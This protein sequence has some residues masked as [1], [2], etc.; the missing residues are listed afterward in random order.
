[1]THRPVPPTVGGRSKRRPILLL[2]VLATVGITAAAPLRLQERNEL[3]VLMSSGF[4]AAY[5]ELVPLFE[6]GRG[7][8]LTTT[9]GGSVGP[10]QNTIAARLARGEVAD[11]VILAADGLDGLVEQ[12]RVVP[13]SR[14]DLATTSI[15]VAVPAGTA[16]P[17][18]RSLDGLRNALLAAE[19]VAISS[20][21]SGTYLAEVVFPRLGIADEVAAKTV[22][23]GNVGAA[24]A[25]READLGFQ[26]MSELL[27]EGGIDILG[28]IPSEVQLVT[29]Y[30]AAL[31]TTAR[32]PALGRALIYFL[33]SSAAWETI[34]GAGMQPINTEAR[35]LPRGSPEGPAHMVAQSS[36]TAR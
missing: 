3:A 14:V 1:M 7:V 33:A 20:S 32:D 19:R 6:R 9:R 21:V 17:D 35:S 22:I 2:L 8:T 25:R 12:G 10:G 5:S 4:F 26:Q 30:S 13:E 28:P 15:G 36:R 24:L 11:V 31:T 29:V 27:P 23:T 16:P 18:T 34:R